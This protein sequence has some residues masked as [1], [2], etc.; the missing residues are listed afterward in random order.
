MP[1][2][3]QGSRQQKAKDTVAERI[4]FPVRVGLLGCGT[5]GGGVIQLIQENA[6]YLASRVGAPLEIRHVL[7]RDAEKDRVPGCKKEWLTTEPDVVLA[8]DAVDI[9]IEVMGGEEPAKTY[10]ERAMASGKGVVTANKYLLA[11]HGPRLVELAN[12]QGVDLAFEASVGGGI[13][14]IRTL[15]EALTSDWVLSVHAILNGTCNYILTRM[16]D[17]GIGFDEVLAEAQ[18]LG[19][20]EADPSLDVDGHDAAQK[21]VV[22]SMLAFGAKVP[23]EQV[24]VEG[25]RNIDQLDFR[26]A[27]RFGYTIKHLAIGYDHGSRIEL[28]VHP[29]MVP[30]GSVLANIDGV[31]NGAFLQGRALG[32]C[33]LVGRGAGDMPTAVSVVADLVDVARSKIEG[34]PGLQTR[35]IQMKERPLMP[36]DE[37]RAR[38]YLRFDVGDEPGVLGLISTALGRHDVSIEQMMQEGRASESGD[39]VP[40]LIITHGC[41]EGQVQAAM[42]EIAGHSF[43]KGAPRFI[44]IEDV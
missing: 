20:A 40:V 5:V 26:F 27:D 7:V 39:A 9:V 4:K 17:E 31:L 37:V 16:R 12:E 42:G 29:A 10:V 3:R 11:K 33:L 8:E 22:M 28:R 21:L 14:I 36:L 35:G 30:R 15:R 6:E 32:P 34:E 43:L 38:Y 13:P 19:Y 24:K 18:R 23:V 44:R 1:R 2:G 25:I 41:T